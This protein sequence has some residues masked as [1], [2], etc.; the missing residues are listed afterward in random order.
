MEAT[1]L[2]MNSPRKLLSNLSIMSGVHEIML[3]FK[4]FRET[5]L[6]SRMAINR[7]FD[8][9]ASSSSLPHMISFIAVATP[10]AHLILSLVDSHL[11]VS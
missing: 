1:S 8:H 5:H 10:S 4:Q 11:S 6:R 3:A 9:I 7:R 2:D